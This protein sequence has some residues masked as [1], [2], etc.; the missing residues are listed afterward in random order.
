[1]LPPEDGMRVIHIHIQPKWT[2]QADVFSIV[3]YFC[4]DPLKRKAHRPDELP[5]LEVDDHGQIPPKREIHLVVF[6]FV[7]L[8]DGCNI[9]L[10][11]L[12]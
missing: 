9:M 8:S 3:Q 10:T 11:V 5:G 7:I 2:R 12:D 1:M 6:F 4:R